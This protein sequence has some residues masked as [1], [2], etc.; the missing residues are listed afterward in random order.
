MKKVITIEV[1]ISESNDLLCCLIK[2]NVNTK[3][4]GVKIMCDNKELKLNFSHVGFSAYHHNNWVCFP[5]IE[6][7]TV[8]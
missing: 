1:A 8:V 6:G 3:E 4:T 2:G 7:D 5:K